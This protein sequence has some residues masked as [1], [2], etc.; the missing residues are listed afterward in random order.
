[1]RYLEK[2]VRKISKNQLQELFDRIERVRSFIPHLSII[3]KIKVETNKFYNA[4]QIYKRKNTE[5]RNFFSFLVSTGH[6][7]REWKKIILLVTI[8]FLKLYYLEAILLRWSYMITLASFPL[9]SFSLPY[10]HERHAWTVKIR[11]RKII[12][13][14]KKNEESVVFDRCIIAAIND[15]WKRRWTDTEGTWVVGL[16]SIESRPS[17]LVNLSHALFKVSKRVLCGL[18]DE[19]IRSWSETIQRALKFYRRISR[20]P[21][22]RANNHSTFKLNLNFIRGISKYPREKVKWTMRWI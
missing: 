19:I 10:Y 15:S 22:E 1:M 8:C 2:I 3:R 4:I 5:H 9:V 18:T 14:R 21:S 13:K 6:F 20:P 7:D 17:L 11:C 16:A 12:K